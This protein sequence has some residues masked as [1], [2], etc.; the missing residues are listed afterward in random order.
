MQKSEIFV[1]SENN[2]HR[3]CVLMGE[4][5]REWQHDHPDA[6]VTCC[7]QSEHVLPGLGDDIGN[8]RLTL[9]IFYDEG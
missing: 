7:S 3:N 9:T 4:R 6:H 1:V 5:L 8:P 2:A